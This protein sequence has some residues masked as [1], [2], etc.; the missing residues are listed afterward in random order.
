VES[1]G[2]DS[3]IHGVDRNQDES[4]RQPRHAQRCVLSGLG[5]MEENLTSSGDSRW[6]DVNS[7]GRVGNY[8]VIAGTGIRYHRGRRIQTRQ[9]G[10]RLQV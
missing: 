8:I 6:A 4:V 9:A 1:V 7:G 5:Y 2:T 3:D 10:Y